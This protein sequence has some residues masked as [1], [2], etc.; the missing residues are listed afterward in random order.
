IGAWLAIAG[1][2]GR[3]GSIGAAVSGVFLALV[4]AVMAIGMWGRYSWARILQMVFAGVGALTCL[5]TLPSGVVFFYMLRPA[6]RIQFSGRRFRS[7][8]STGEA[9]ILASDS[10]EGAFAGALIGT[11][12]LGVI[13][14]AAAGFVMSRFHAASERPELASPAP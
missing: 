2:L 6:T 12:L 5:M 4:S 8:L 7:Q 10:R 14:S 13:I 11:L 1:D 9:E 3:G